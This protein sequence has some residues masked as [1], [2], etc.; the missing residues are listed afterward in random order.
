MARAKPPT[1]PTSSSRGGGSIEWRDNGDAILVVWVHTPEGRRRRKRVVHDV[2]PAQAARALRQWYVECQRWAEEQG[3]GTGGKRLL[4]DWAK[5][6][7][8][9]CED[10]LAPQTVQAYRQ[11]LEHRI[12]PALGHIALQQLRPGHIEH[13]AELLGQRGQWIGGHRPPGWTAPADATPEEVATSLEK[14][15]LAARLSPATQRRIL[16]TLSAM[17]Q[18]AVR[19]QLI[20]AN[21]AA[22]VTRPREAR[23]ETAHYDAAAVRQVVEALAS[24]PV[25]FRALV[26]LAISTGARRGELLALQWRDIR[27]DDHQVL[28]TASA[29]APTGSPQSL[30][31]T[32]GGRARVAPLTTPAGAA[33]EEWRA[34]QDTQRLLAEWR[35]DE[36]GD[37]LFTGAAGDWMRL[38]VVSRAWPRFLAKHELPPLS[39]H[40]LR[41]TAA[42]LWLGSGLGP[43]DVQQLLGHSQASTT[44][45]I[46]GHASNA[47]DRARAVI[48][49]AAASHGGAPPDEGASSHR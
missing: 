3:G 39:L 1:S 48:E 23:R 18:R 45:N 7:L 17:L 12:L 24:E 26:H 43:N 8:G 34:L 16:A 32:K 42:T 11:H 47:L 37:F 9:F 33:L 29:Q 19:R 49:Q 44:L 30:K 46:Y 20:K 14:A 25:W 36:R 35:D 27:W 21:P 2:T 15:R 13:F 5:E 28:I 31:T 10:R 4:R 22:N 41:H 6:W 38:E 40:G